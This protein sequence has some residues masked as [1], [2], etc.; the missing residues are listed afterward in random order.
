MT[1]QERLAQLD[2]AIQA[3]MVAGQEYRHEGRQVRRADLAQLLKMR[4][5]ILEEIEVNR[6]GSKTSVAVFEGR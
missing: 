2:E 5:E 6:S 1:V 3:V 4:Q